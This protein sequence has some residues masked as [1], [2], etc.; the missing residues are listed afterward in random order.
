VPRSRRVAGDD[1][2]P[3]KAWMESYA[4]AMTLLLAFFV[5]MFAFALVDE[6]KFFDFKVGMVQA[7]GM[8]NPVNDD[9]SGMLLSG[10]GIAEVPGTLAISTEEV[11]ELL[12][13]SD[14]Q[15]GTEVTV[16][17]A[18]ALRDLLE[19]A[20]VQVG[21]DDHVAVEIDERGVV[22][23]FDDRVLFPSGSNRLIGDGSTILTQVAAVLGPIDNHISV[24]G[25]T[26]SVPTNGTTWPSNWELSTA[27]ATT[28]V[29]HLLDVGRLADPRLSAT[30]Y[31]DT[32]PR[33]A[34]TSDD[35]RRQNRRVEVVVVI[36]GILEATDAVSAIDPGINGGIDLPTSS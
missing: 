4:D 19:R 7:I 18:E 29:R 2:G 24:E 12:A 11:R 6:Q 15:H 16:D 34:N 22:I 5:M 9:P 10:D 25:H 28:V 8:S 33:A 17:E 23:R 32:R 35:G 20:L 27:R 31:A 1:T 14:R 26:D 21:A 30:G 36:D 13:E 3:S